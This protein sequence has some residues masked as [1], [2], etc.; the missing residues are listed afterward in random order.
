MHMAQRW[1]IASARVP[2]G[3]L[4]AFITLIAAGCTP[5]PRLPV[6]KV[7]GDETVVT[8]RDFAQDYLDLGR[9]YYDAGRFADAI[10][11]F[12]RV[13][14][15]NPYSDEAHA[16][17]GMANHRLGK[18][19]RAERSFR[20]AL[21]FNPRNIVARNGIAMVSEDERVRKESLQAAISFEPEMTELRNNL[22]AVYVKSGEFEKAEEACRTAIKLDSTNAHAFYNLGYAFQQQKKLDKALG[23]YR[24]ALRHKIDW[25]RVLNN[26]GLIYYQKGEFGYA[27]Q[28]Y[29]RAIAANDAESTFH[30]NLA[31]AYEAVG[32]RLESQWVRDRSA[33]DNEWRTLYRQGADELRIYLRLKPDATDAMRIRIKMDN[34]RMR[35]A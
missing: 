32:S 14:E 25:A 20:L 33:K 9:A 34:M 21:R 3:V 29:K 23:Q 6:P 5:T 2:A 1:R 30:Y 16:S 22:C 10:D 13:L 31:L 19:S 18:R 28:H 17:I 35:G 7:I 27:I 15:I 11:Q 12:K 8:D 4:F 24:M 26:M